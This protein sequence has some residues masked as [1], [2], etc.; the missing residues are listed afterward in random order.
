[1]NNDTEQNLIEFLQEVIVTNSPACR[2]NALYELLRLEPDLLSKEAQNNLISSFKA[3]KEAKSK[4]GLTDAQKRWNAKKD[5][6]EKESK[7]NWLFFK[8]SK[9]GS[10]C[11]ACPNRYELDEPMILNRATSK[12]YHPECA[13]P[14]AINEV[15]TNPFYINY[16]KGNDQ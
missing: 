7:V 12:G 8:K 10:L 14:E 11:T 9:R 13:P 16:T 5:K 2:L 4:A 1:M 3:S 15:S 6:I